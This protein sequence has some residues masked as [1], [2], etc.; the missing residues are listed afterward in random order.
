MAVPRKP[1][2]DGDVV[3]RRAILTHLKMTGP[4]R[5]ADMADRFDLTPMAVRLHLYDLEK[6]GVVTATSV[7]KGRGRPSKIWRLTEKADDAF[8]DSHRDLAVELLGAARAAFGEEGVAQ[9]VERRGKDQIKRYRERL[10]KKS[11]LKARLAALA[12]IRTEG[13]YMAEI[14]PALERGQGWLFVENHCPI[15]TMARACTGLCANELEVFQKTLGS[16]VEVSRAEHILGGDRR[17][18]YRVRRR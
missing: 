3:T 14:M 7:A 13:G 1:A 15:C 6:Q 9:L 5:A 2:D 18:A 12:D 8:P 11:D 4:S 10:G 17:C 16:D